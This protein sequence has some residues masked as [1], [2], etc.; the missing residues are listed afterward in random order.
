MRRERE[1]SYHVYRAGSPKSCKVSRISLTPHNDR[2]PLSIIKRYI[3]SLTELKRIKG[4]K[5]RRIKAL[6]Q[7]NLYD[8]PQ[9]QIETA[10]IITNVLL[11]G[12]DI[13]N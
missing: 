6:V 1:V 13:S 4:A 2:N 12:K 3:P 8:T 5:I 9:R 10:R 11:A 7:N